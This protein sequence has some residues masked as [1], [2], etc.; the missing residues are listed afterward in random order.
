MCG[1]FNVPLLDMSESN[2]NTSIN[3]QSP[4]INFLDFARGIAIIMMLQGHFVSTTF[5][6][7]AADEHYTPSGF[8]SFWLQIRGYTAP[9]FFTVSGMVFT[10][11]LL[12]HHH[13]P[14]RN[15]MR[16]RKGVVRGLLL[17]F[18]GYFLQLNVANFHVYLN[19]GMNDRMFTFHVLNSIGVGILVLI[20]VYAVFI[21]SMR[22]NGLFVYPILT[23]LSFLASTYISG[24]DGYVPQGSYEI[25][26]N[27]LKGPNSIFPLF[28]WLGYM[29]YGAFIGSVF[30]NFRRLKQR[31]WYPVLIAFTHFI[32]LSL[33]HYAFLGTL[34]LL[35]LPDEGYREIY[36]IKQLSFLAILLSLLMYTEKFLRSTNS[37][38]LMGRNTLTI[39]VLHI[40]V[41]YGAL[42]G[43]GIKTYWE[44]EL[45]AYAPVL[46]T[47]AFVLLFWGITMAQV[48]SK[49]KWLKLR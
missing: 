22:L 33:M 37:I 41:L 12:K 40:I 48:K 19:G 20:L 31:S 8:F 46:Y 5:Y 13:L 36:A 34:S 17:L 2:M 4:R 1:L 44:H 49:K 32:A 47:I 7:F 35:D 38:V 16:I 6:G 18:L 39:Y 29:F 30:V 45:D 11:S 14:L 10:Y 15:N 24:I 42:I 21:K 28:P 43:V 27:M 23:F 9:L 3:A 26:Q 25:F